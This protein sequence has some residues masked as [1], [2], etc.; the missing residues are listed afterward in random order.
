[1]KKSL[2]ILVGI[3]GLVTGCDESVAACD[4][5]SSGLV[6]QS[7][8]LTMPLLGRDNE[9]IPLMQSY[10]SRFTEGGDAILCMR[11]LR[12]MI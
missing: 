8:V 10:P 3:V 6:A 9:M 7:Y 2:A 12:P 5:V 1:M 11:G 4:E